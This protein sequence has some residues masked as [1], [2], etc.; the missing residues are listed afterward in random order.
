MIIKLSITNISNW[1]DPIIISH[2]MRINDVTLWLFLTLSVPFK[3]SHN[4][5]SINFP[6]FIH[7]RGDIVIIFK[8]KQIM[9]KKYW[10][11]RELES[12]PQSHGFDDEIR[13]DPASAARE[14]TTVVLVTRRRTSVRKSTKTWST[15]LVSN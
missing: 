9:T 11:N 7:D 15:Y 10:D 1:V 2:I 4:Q 13:A 5:F 3:S 8:E 6:N 12:L 14:M